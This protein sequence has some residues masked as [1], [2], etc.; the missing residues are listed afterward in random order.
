M[1]RAQV[2]VDHVAGVVV[3]DTMVVVVAADSCLC[4]MLSCH[5]RCS[6]C[7]P[8]MRTFA[9]GCLILVTGL[10]PGFFFTR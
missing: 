3:D 4:V 5:C 8:N 6:V 10:S 9:H 1:T 2:V 7:Q